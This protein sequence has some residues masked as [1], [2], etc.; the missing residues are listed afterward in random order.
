MRKYILSTII[1]LI[2]FVL[3]LPFTAEAVVSGYNNVTFDA[4]T[5]LYISSLGKNLVVSSGGEIKSLTTYSDHINLTLLQGS[6]ITITSSDK[7]KMINSIVETACGS[8]E[9]TITITTSETS[10]YTTDQVV[11]IT[12]SGYCSTGGSSSGGGVIAD[13]TA[14]SISDVLATPAKKSAV[15]TWTT[16]EN[17]ISWVVYGTTTNYGLE[18]KTTSY[19]TSHSITLSGLTA[20]TDYHYQVKSKDSSGNTK[21]YSDQTFTTLA[22]EEKPLPPVTTP[23]SEMTKEQL[24]VK[25]TEITAQIQVLL[26]ELAKLKG[27]AVITGVPSTF[28]FDRSLESKMAGKDVKY[29]Q[30]VLNISP[31]TRLSATGV[32]S[33]GHET[34]YFGPKTKSAV[35]KFQEKYAKEILGP[36]GLTHGTG[37]VGKT[38]RDKLNSLLGR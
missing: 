10:G 31:D 35:I 15:I 12:P 30:I 17:S 21:S 13:T 24:K 37:Y 4:A 18:E 33:P 6:H 36:W 19:T 8:S 16:G 38:T 26:A 5:N 9:S 3:I 20:E 25:I 14:P 1:F 22:T 7:L 28:S 32:G 27:E 34:S 29:L 2:G 23:V 11:T